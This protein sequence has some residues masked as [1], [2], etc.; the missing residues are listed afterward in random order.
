MKLCQYLKQV[1]LSLNASLADVQRETGISAPH[2]C[3]VE[4]GE[5]IPGLKN[6]VTLCDYYGIS[7]NDVADIVRGK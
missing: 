1:R 3:N 7:L 5:Y 2:M 6:M 4:K